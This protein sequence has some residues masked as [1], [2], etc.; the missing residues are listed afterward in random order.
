M[1]NFA[2]RPSIFL[3]LSIML[4]IVC[5]ACQTATNT[6]TST[7]TANVNATPAASI[8]ASASPT[9]GAGI[10]AREPEKYQAK[11][12]MTAQTTGSGQNISI[13]PLSAV[14]ARSGSDRR[15]SFVLP[16]NEEVIYIDRAD[17]RYIVLPKRKQYAELTPQSTGFE[18]PRA[19]T[20]GQIVDQL[21]NLQ[22]YE[23]VGEESVNGRT[24]IKYRYAG[25]TKTGTQAGDVQTEAIVLVDKETGLPLRSE[26]VSESQTGNVKGVTGLK[27]ITEMTDIKT[28]VDPTLFEVPPGLTKVSDQQVRQSV[29]AVG[30]AVIAIIGQI[31]QSA[32]NNAPSASPAATT[33]A[34]PAR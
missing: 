13:P 20:P 32:N 22:G 17:K 34:T 19:M 15:F 25:T 5:G 28:D 11:L 23:R 30:R 8:N 2:G 29:D 7:N 31:M 6:N 1:R 18:V 24:A 3:F 21:K 9:P 14:V 33:A 26:T 12:S 16:G 27:I 10:E 4:A